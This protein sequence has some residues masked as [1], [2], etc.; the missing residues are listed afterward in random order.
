[1]RTSLSACLKAGAP[2]HQYDGLKSIT[3]F[4]PREWAAATNRSQSASVPSRGSTAVALAMPKP[5]KRVSGPPC[6]GQST[7]ITE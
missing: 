3:T 6:T 1:M 4:M 7:L 5:M 2:V